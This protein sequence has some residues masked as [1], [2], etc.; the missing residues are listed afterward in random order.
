MEILQEISKL[1]N[2]LNN[3][4]IQN[5][6]PFWLTKMPDQEHGGFHGRING[7]GKLIK[8]SSKGAVLNAR[9]LWTFSAAYRMLGDK[10]YL[11]AANRAKQYLADKFTDKENGGVYW[12]LDY[13]GSPEETKKQ[14]YAQTFAIYGLSEY[15]EA[16]GKKDSLVQA[17]RLFN[18]IECYSFD[19]KQNGYIEALDQEW[20][21]LSDMRLSQKDT[22]AEKTMNTHLHILEA[23]TALY[24]VWKNSLLKSKLKNLI[25][26]FL[27]KIIDPTSHN[28]H[29]FFDMDW[30][31]YDNTTSNGHDIEA[32][33]LLYQA[34]EV[35]D[36]NEVIDRV[37]IICNLITQS[38]ANG[39]RPD[40]SMVSGDEREWWVQAET[41]VG[42]FNHYQR[43]G[44]LD[45]LIKSTNCWKF[46]KEKIIDNKQGEWFWSANLDGTPN[47][48]DDKAGIWKCP[49]HNGRMCLEII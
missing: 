11:E 40:G 46:I 2:E 34:A 14:I 41:V 39:I 28:L 44:S 15:Y 43:T 45:S 22:N 17:I 48:K 31:N 16:T 13:K 6:L 42:F 25:E 10:R 30:N 47:T 3:E 18:L 49:Y 23:Y 20:N 26:I 21:L 12:M 33:W 8:N 27:E 1:K 9:I 35:L 38:A 5:I 19:S 36:D 32:S 7:E 24:R 4:L 29:Q 37:E